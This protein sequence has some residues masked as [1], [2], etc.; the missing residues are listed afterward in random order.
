M[1]CSYCQKEIVRNLT[2]KEI[3]F[4]WSIQAE[5]CPACKNRFTLIKE[6]ACPT[7]GKM[8]EVEMCD[9]CRL[10]QKKYPNYS[11][12]HKAL[13]VY[14]QAFKDWIHQYKFLGD[15]RLAATFTGEIQQFFAKRKDWII[16]Y[17][18]LSEERYQE[19]GFNQTL[20]FLQAAG[21]KNRELLI[22]N[23]DTTAQSKKNRQ[24]RLAAPQAFIAT[25]AAKQI[26][27]KKVL[28]A[29]DVYTTGRTLFHAA[30]ILLDYKPR[31]L[32]TFSLAR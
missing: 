32:A 26:K 20:A 17:V 8:G 31:Q 30:E 4:P 5:R 1:K 11:F 23:K 27:N 9:E 10:W 24:E 2:V 13:F 29:D 14:D 15:Y 18:P 7:C 25:E 19:R 16:T 22:K 21:I 6:P 3:C 28:L 12:C